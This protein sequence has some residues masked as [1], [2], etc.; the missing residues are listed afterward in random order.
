M[1]GIP[2]KDDFHTKTKNINV[3]FQLIKTRK[4]TKFLEY[5]SHLQPDEVDVNTKDE[6]GNYLVFFAIVM[7][8]PKILKKLI[9]YN[10]RLD[11]L[12]SDG[13][14]ILYYPIR[15]NYPK[16]ID[17]LLRL[18]KKIVG[19]PLVN[20]K[21]ARGIVPIFYAVKYKNM[22][23]L[24]ELLNNGADANYRNNDNM[25]ALHLAVIRK[26]AAMVEILTS[27]IK[28]IDARTNFGSTALHYACN[29]LLP[30]IVK[31]LLDKGA[32]QNVIETEYSFY[33]I[34]YAVVQNNVEITKILIDYGANIN[35]QDYLGN[36][37][38]HYAIINNNLEILSYIMDS[39]DI[40][41]TSVY[42][43]NINGNN[44]SDNDD[45][46]GDDSSENHK[47]TPKPIPT[48]SINPTLVNIDGLT[49]VHLFLYNY[50]EDYNYFLE[51]LIPYSNMNYQDNMGNTLLHIIIE[52]N[53][54]E[55]LANLLITK[56]LNI[57]IKNNKGTSVVEMV[58]IS[59]YNFILETV[60]KS[61]ITY[62][63]KYPNGWLTEFDN[64]CS[65]IDDESKCIETVKKKITLEKVSVPIKKNKKNITIIENELVQFGTFTGSLL[66][67][68]VGFKY[69]C[70]KYKDVASLFHSEQENTQEL[71]K[72]NRAMGIYENPSQH[73]IHFEIRWVYQRLFLPP[74]FENIIENI[75]KNRKSKYIIIPIG[76][77]LSNGNHTN[78]LFYDI[79]KQ[80]MER[81]EPHGSDYPSSFNYNPDLLDEILYKKFNNVVQNIY[82]KNIKIEYYPPKKYLPKIG[83]Q[84]LENTEIN[85]NK[86]IGDPNGFCTLWTIWYFDY[87]LEYNEVW[88]GSLIK[89]LIKQIKINNYSFRTVIRNYSKY[90]TDLRD[91]YLEQ[92]G[93]HINDYLNNRLNQHELRQLLNVI[94]MD[95]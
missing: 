63:K 77:I 16:I 75:I 82:K 78:G 22:F 50:K 38:I 89:N 7:N 76:I 41:S 4:Q 46:G 65:K 31:I 56:K 21:D 79:D 32:D 23:A 84:T 48:S 2:S 64:E 94:L 24:R 33:P 49:I 83:F 59:N 61:Y 37:V 9:E 47:P 10:S 67:M 35:N 86:N 66:D 42:T 5:L 30:N 88:P 95:K 26:N 43:E 15:Y 27:Y 55:N 58:H 8:N 18:D 80:V 14:S 87:R 36:T 91:Y 81:F 13:Y 44:D 29:F 20:L 54:W 68:I 52:N 57:F 92:I 72:Y 25:N 60:S 34:F 51:K 39:Y 6:N 19:I 17:I 70:K 73:I 40:R 53:L 69:L 74:N 45:D 85:V 62:L 12:D 1:Q 28:N 71:E 93:K 3:L 90:V 11:V